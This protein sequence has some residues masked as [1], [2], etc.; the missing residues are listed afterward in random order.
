MATNENIEAIEGML[1]TKSLSMILI[2]NN[3]IEDIVLEKKP[4]GK[5]KIRQPTKE[6]AETLF[7]FYFHGLSEKSRLFFGSPNPLFIRPLAS[8]AELS[9]RIQ[10]WPQTK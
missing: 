1:E 4:L 6:E 7:D 10:K 2:K 8:A 5:L 3:L 9:K